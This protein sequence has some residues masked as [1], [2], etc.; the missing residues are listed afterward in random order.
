MKITRL[1]GLLGATALLAT[2]AACGG[3]SGAGSP[4]DATQGYLQAVL[5]E[6]PEK[7]CNLTLQDGKVR[8]GDTLDKCVEEGEKSLED[9]EKER[10]KLSDDDRKALETQEKE[11]RKQFEQLLDDGPK[12]VGDEKDGEVVVTYEFDG[13]EGPIT[14]KKLDGN[15]Y[16][17]DDLS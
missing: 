12:K 10:K 8:E 17:A 14:T 11:L 4:E 5:D 2:T 6:K 7:L 3:G 15:W 9:A 1:A 16:V 13:Q